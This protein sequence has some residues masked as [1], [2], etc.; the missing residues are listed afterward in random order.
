VIEYI[1]EVGVGLM[2]VLAWYGGTMRERNR[3]NE[4]NR[5][6]SIEANNADTTNTVALNQS[7]LA[8][9]NFMQGVMKEQAEEH[10]KRIGEEQAR[11]ES[12][13]AEERARTDALRAELNECRSQ[14]QDATAATK[15]AREEAQAA[16]TEAAGCR[17][18]AEKMRGELATLW[19]QFE[20]QKIERHDFDI[21]KR[22]NEILIA[23]NQRLRTNLNALRL[24]REQHLARETAH[25]GPVPLDLST[26]L[27]F[28]DTD[29]DLPL[30]GD[31]TTPTESPSSYTVKTRRHPHG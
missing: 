31:A 6:L 16:K 7:D 17:A 18:D 19:Q 8:L 24:L 15:L 20:A 13:R 30:E 4:K 10:R 2:G 27:D 9:A 5:E 14:L 29:D 21:L 22:S 12:V 11:T 23:E 26:S 3:A 28:E 25:G 1:R